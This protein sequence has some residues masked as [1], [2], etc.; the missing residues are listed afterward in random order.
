MRLPLF[1]MMDSTISLLAQR[2]EYYND[3]ANELQALI[4]EILSS[5]AL[6]GV[7]VRVKSEKSLR[8]KMLRK[9]L[10]M[11][12]NDQYDVLNNLS[13]LIG[14]R[15]ECRFMREENELYQKLCD[16]CILPHG[17]GT[18]SLPSHPTIRFALSIEQPQQQQNGLSIYRIDG[19]YHKNGV[20]VPFELQI[21]SL[22][23]VFWAEVEHQL[24]Y[25]NNSYILMDDFLKKLLYSNYDNL[26][27][28]DASLQ[29]L[30]DHM[31]VRSPDVFTVQ[32]ANMQ[33]LLAKTISDVFLQRMQVQMGYSL[34]LNNACDILAQYLLTRSG[35]TINPLHKFITQIHSV[36]LLPLTFDDALELEGAYFAE[37]AF[38]NAIGL[39]L[40]QQININYE[41]NVFF[42][43]LFTLEEGNHLDSFSSFIEMYCSRF[44]NETL[45]K[46]A[47]LE[48][49]QEIREQIFT[50]LSD[51]L[52]SS[53]DISIL[54]E[55]TICKLENAIRDICAE[56]CDSPELMRLCLQCAVE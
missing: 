51:I 25:K 34:R 22:V 48:R 50:H 24:I 42:R 56:G 14:L 30:Y 36:S 45:Y 33:P 2:S 3:C 17:G 7:H 41:W 11:Q 46:A 10:Y 49:R 53:G 15:A 52:V 27:Q 9:Q 31:Q 21:K 1:D 13:D 8:E 43:M 32:Y 23:H 4:K 6:L 26:K 19:K 16:A 55:K 28:M 47:P 5:D 54:F 39:F 37:N 18:F 29:L 35:N 38:H 44:E 20:S 12:Y 40:S